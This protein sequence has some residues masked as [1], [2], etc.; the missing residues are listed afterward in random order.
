MTTRPSDET[1]EE[2]EEGDGQGRGVLHGDVH[3]KTVFI[4]SPIVSL[5]FGKSI[6]INKDKSTCE[7]LFHM[8]AYQQLTCD[9]HFNTTRLCF[10]AVT[11]FN[12]F[13][14]F[15]DSSDIST[16]VNI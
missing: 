12:N 15:G 14:V 10:P 13:N 4:C 1:A 5:F 11:S 3:L 9:K 7:V 2:V 6:L 8:A 16:I